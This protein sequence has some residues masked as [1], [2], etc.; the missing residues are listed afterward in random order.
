MQECTELWRMAIREIKNR[1]GIKTREIAERADLPEKTIS[2]I[3]S[4]EAKAPSVDCVRRI[5]RAME[6][7][8]G[9]VFAESSA[10]ITTQDVEKLQEQNKTLEEEI[11][12][13]KADH[14]SEL[15]RLKLE[16]AEKLLAVHEHYN[17]I[18]SQ[19]IVS[20]FGNSECNT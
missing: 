1:K 13:M 10:V 18:V 15:L 8:W 11:N 5:I 12:R 7:T 2:R 19:S 16:C 17:G 3:L 14:E 9:E 20:N 6:A 4:G